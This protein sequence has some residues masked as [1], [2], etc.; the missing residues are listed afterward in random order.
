MAQDRGL[1]GTFDYDTWLATEPD[2]CPHEEGYDEDEAYDRW[3]DAQS[4]HLAER[5]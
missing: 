5:L 1:F 4:E 3:V 2:Y